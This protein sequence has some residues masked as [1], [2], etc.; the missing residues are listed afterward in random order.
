M[1]KWVIL[2]M[3][4]INLIAAIVAEAN[5]IS[6][7]TI[8]GMPAQTQIGSSYQ[9]RYQVTDNGPAIPVFVVGFPLPNITYQVGSCAPNG[10][11]LPTGGSCFINL[12]F[13]P[14]AV[15]TYQQFFLVVNTY[16]QIQVP[17]NTTVKPKPVCRAGYQRQFGIVSL[18]AQGQVRY[19]NSANNVFNRCVAFESYEALAIEGNYIAA[20]FFGLA[21]DGVT[22]QS[23]T[24]AANVNGSTYW[25]IPTPGGNYSELFSAPAI[26]SKGYVYVGD[27]QGYLFAEQTPTSATPQRFWAFMLGGDL[28]KLQPIIDNKGLIY[29]GSSS[30][31]FT[32][33]Y[34]DG[35]YRWQV[36]LDTSG[37]MQKAALDSI[38]GVVYVV[39]SSGILYALDINTGAPKWSQK[40][41]ITTVP[42]V[43]PDGT[44]YVGTP[45]GYLY[46]IQG[47]P[48]ANRLPAMR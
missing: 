8:Q 32:A 29:I 25:T 37:V 15:G 35:T 5:N 6:V 7:T 36:F 19:I 34:P 27:N 23:S 16:G 44:V 4:I 48:H 46:A 18:T 42:V 17:L 14:T 45:I 2:I 39:T 1:K 11:L 26:D 10:Q 24:V 22:W 28:S 33:I 38:A 47:D 20:S 31:F 43:G 40:L 9:L 3:L 21:M 41:G 12:T 30:G 13:L